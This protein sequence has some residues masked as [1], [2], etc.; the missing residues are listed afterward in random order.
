VQPMRSGA[1]SRATGRAPGGGRGSSPARRGPR[2]LPLSGRP[3][4]CSA[5]RASLRASPRHGIHAWVRRGGPAQQAL[6][7]PAT[8][9]HAVPVDLFFLG[10]EDP[11]DHDRAARRNPGAGTDGSRNPPR[12]APSKGAAEDVRSRWPRRSRGRTLTAR[13]PDGAP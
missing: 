9:V 12:L 1:L 10:R 3:L 6:G 2:W 5:G 11:L 7:V 4:V 8:R 13:R